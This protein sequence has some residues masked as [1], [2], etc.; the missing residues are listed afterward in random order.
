MVC[1]LECCVSFTLTDVLSVGFDVRYIAENHENLQHVL[2]FLTI[3][4]ALRD[5]EIEA[6]V[7]PSYPDI[8]EGDRLL[9]RNGPNTSPPLL[10]PAHTFPGKKEVKA[11]NGHYEIKLSTTPF[12]PISPEPTPLLDASQLSNLNPVSFNCTSCTLPVVRAS[13]I[14]SYRD[15]PSEHWEE[16]VD[17]WMCHSDQRL[18]DQITKR[19]RGFWPE[20]GQALVGGSYIL[21]QASSMVQMNLC[22]SDQVK[23]RLYLMLYYS[24]SAGRSRRPALEIHQRLSDS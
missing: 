22:P 1:L 3:T 10:L 12:T 20:P 4:G 2:V 8:N 5:V 9:I 24:V 6:E 15:L 18:H 23:V 17:A 14:E 11:Q 16:L 21:F 7:I 19:S 13:T